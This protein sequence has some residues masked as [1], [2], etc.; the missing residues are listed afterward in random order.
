MNPP[1]GSSPEETAAES[2]LIPAEKEEWRSRLS[3]GRQS[4]TRESMTFADRQSFGVFVDEDITLNERDINVAATE[5]VSPNLPRVTSALLSRRQSNSPSASSDGDITRHLDDLSDLLGSGARDQHVPVDEGQRDS[6]ASMISPP[7]EDQEMEPQEASPESVP[8]NSDRQPDEPVDIPSPA[9]VVKAHS[10]LPESRK[11]FSG[12]TTEEEDITLHHY[13]PDESNNTATQPPIARV[14]SADKPPRMC[15]PRPNPRQDPIARLQEI[16]NSALQPQPNVS[17]PGVPT[18]PALDNFNFERF[19]TAVEVVFGQLERPQRPSIMISSEWQPDFALDSEE[20][21]VYEQV[22]SQDVLETL[23][24]QMEKYEQLCAAEESKAVLLQ[25]QIEEEGPPLYTKV[26]SVESIPFHELEFYRVKMKSLRKISYLKARSEWVLNRQTW[27]RDICSNIQ[28]RIQT[29]KQV[30]EAERKSAENYKSLLQSLMRGAEEL[31][32]DEI[33]MN[34]RSQDDESEQTMQV[35][36]DFIQEFSIYRDCRNYLISEMKEEEDLERQKADLLA[37]STKLSATAREIRPYA[38][39]ASTTTLRKMVAERS[40]LNSIISR[41]SGIVPMQIDKNLICLR[42]EDMLEVQFSL[43]DER[44]INTSCRPTEYA[45]IESYPVWKS[46][47]DGAVS[48]ATSNGGMKLARYVRD[49]PNALFRSVQLLSHTKNAYEDASRYF[50]THLGTLES[51]SLDYEEGNPSV[52]LTARASFYSL[53]ARCKF[54]I[55]VELV[56]AVVGQEIDCM[57]QDLVIQEVVRYFGPT[58]KDVQLADTLTSCSTS[59]CGS[60]SISGGLM[61]IWNLLQ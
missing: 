23:Q 24:L 32:L 50:E 44:V 18:D 55:V 39:A 14:V 56:T 59:A 52:H 43:H 47:L 42:L 48:F 29:H 10:L 28:S 21:R 11:L 6:D 3:L 1:K 22:M 60:L 51:A 4:M 53:Q 49:I 41:V 35:R 5:D 36:R 33:L 34:A 27:E 13:P 19:L 37:R 12:S 2:I 16:T 46:Y 8:V 54:D 9:I 30:E 58:P 57:R 26:A 38:A 40:D 15:T 25:A 45:E 61:G 17:G 31:E 20:G 7:E